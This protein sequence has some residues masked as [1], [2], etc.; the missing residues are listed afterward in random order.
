[1]ISF[2]SVQNIRVGAIS[3]YGTTNWITLKFDMEDTT[4][5]CIYVEKG[6]EAHKKLM[7]FAKMLDE[8]LDTS[9]PLE[10]PVDAA[11]QPL[12]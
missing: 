4:D 11:P 3:N 9:I 8:W 7:S 6:S 2:H 5:I 10:D 12:E 1:M